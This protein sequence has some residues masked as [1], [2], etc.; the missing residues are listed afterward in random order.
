M[1]SKPAKL[2]IIEDNP[3]DV[4]LLRFAL[5]HHEEHYELDVLRDGEAAI[6]FVQQERDIASDP[7][8]CVIVLDLNLP[9]EDGKTVLTAIKQEPELA[10]IH[11]VALSSFAS[12]RDQVEIQQL[13]AR[14]YRPKPMNLDDW[15]AL[16]GEILGICR[17][18]VAISASG[19]ATHSRG[20]F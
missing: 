7:E 17:E 9:K 5:D 11:V 16:A 18:S 15:I 20:R 19:N 3:G 10:H 13:G 2:L 1:S 4:V 8:P 14:L 6:Q 12:P